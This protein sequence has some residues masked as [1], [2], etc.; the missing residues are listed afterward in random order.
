VGRK[1][2]QAVHMYLIIPAIGLG[3]GQFIGK[4]LAALNPTD[5]ADPPIVADAGQHQT[6]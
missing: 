1:A 3:V 4:Q 6:G 5:A 2:F